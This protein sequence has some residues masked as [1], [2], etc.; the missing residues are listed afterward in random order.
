M[1]KQYLYIVDTAKPYNGSIE[2]T[3]PFVAK[4]DINDTEVHYSGGTFAEYN[5]RKGGTLVA[6]DF[7][8]FYKDYYKPHIDSIQGPFIQ[9]T[10][11]AF[12]QGLECVLPKRWTR[13]GKSQF[14]FVGECETDNIYRCY[15]HVK[16]KFYTALRAI[17]TSEDDIFNLKN[18]NQ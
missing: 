6:L 7:E 15:V 8:T 1:S 14:F 10:L 2:N 11:E 4:K 9:T 12:N 5:K 3:M 16:G 17:T 18:I 13:L